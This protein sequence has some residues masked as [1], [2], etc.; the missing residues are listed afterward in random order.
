MKDR[1]KNKDNSSS[2]GH[3]IRMVYQFTCHSLFSTLGH[4]KI[5]QFQPSFQVLR[6]SEEK[7]TIERL[8]EMDDLEMAQNRK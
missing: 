1:K 2:L 3:N 6:A 5:I 7:Q 4:F 8:V